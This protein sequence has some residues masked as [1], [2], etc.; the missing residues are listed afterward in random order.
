MSTA[1]THIT[2]F[3]AE[4]TNML[5]KKLAGATEEPQIVIKQEPYLNIQIKTEK[6]DNE[7]IELV[8]SDEDKCEKCLINVNGSR[9]HKLNKNSFLRHNG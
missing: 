6:I 5:L 2:S 1:K 3:H 7:V 4:D 9:I 8:S